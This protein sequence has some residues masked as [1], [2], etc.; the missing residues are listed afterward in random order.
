MEGRGLAIRILGLASTTHGFA[1]CVTEGAVRLLDWGRTNVLAEPDMRAALTRLMES[2]RPLFVACELQR[3]R[4]N[5]VRVRTLNRA[6]RAV[7]KERGVMIL[8]VERQLAESGGRGR[9]PV[10]NY[11]IAEAAASSYP[12][13]AS[14]LP[15]KRRIWDG[16]DDRIGILL[17]AAA[18][19]AGWKHF[20]HRSSS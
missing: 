19:A 11:Q 17:A 12:L 1:F 5:A 16:S 10:T 2:S 7:C 13:L 14:K 6:V 9:R 8:C 18:A 3:S 20:K 15:R 4:R